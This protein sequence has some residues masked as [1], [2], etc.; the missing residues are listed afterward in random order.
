[1][2][3]QKRQF[4]RCCVL[5][6]KLTAA[7]A[8]AMMEIGSSLSPWLRK[9]DVIVLTG[10]LGAGKTTFVQGLAK[11][12][13]I[14]YPVQSPTFTL[15]NEHFGQLPLYH[16]DVYRLN[17]GSDA[18]DLGLSEYLDGDGV[19]VLEWAERIEDALPDDLLQLVF[20]I[21]DDDSRVVS[22]I[23]YGSRSMELC[24]SWEASL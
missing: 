10:T 17:S 7:T 1:M 23:P 16:M 4:R 3:L 8:D 18:T 24:D 11:G 2:V 5:S 19:C 15:I 14:H 12:L 20:E 13:G 6:F 9:G 21:A 22:V